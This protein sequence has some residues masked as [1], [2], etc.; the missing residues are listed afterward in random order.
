M[1]QPYRRNHYGSYRQMPMQNNLME[2]MQMIMM[3]KMMNSMGP[4]MSNMG[5]GMSSMG[6]GMGGMGPGMSGMG[7]GMSG[8][9]PG[10]SG[11]GPG[12]GGM[13][14]GMGG[15]GP[16]MGSMVQKMGGMGY[17]SMT[18]MMN[19]KGQGGYSSNRSQMRLQCRPATRSNP[20]ITPTT[21]LTITPTT[22]PTTPTTPP[23]TV[24]STQTP[25]QA[26]AQFPEADKK[27]ADDD[28]KFKVKRIIKEELS[29]VLKDMMT[30]MN[31]SDRMIGQ[32]FAQG[33]LSAI[34]NFVVEN[35]T[36]PSAA[37]P[38]ADM[39][40]PCSSNPCGANARCLS[41]RSGGFT[42]EC[43][44][45]YIRTGQTCTHACNNSPYPAL[46]LNDR[47][48]TFHTSD[49]STAMT[50]V[51]A[52]AM[53]EARGGSM[54]TVKN[55]IEWVN[56]THWLIRIRLHNFSHAHFE[57]PWLGTTRQPNNSN[58]WK[59]EGMAV[60]EGYTFWSV[61]EP[62]PPSSGKHCANIN[63]NNGKAY[64]QM[65]GRRITSCICQ[66]NTPL[67]IMK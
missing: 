47:C 21:P 12:M 58:L 31:E 10:M 41:H 32:V 49:S 8:M 4:G 5:P 6:P 27:M 13:G 9:G 42:C 14:P 26:R 17:S 23:T 65:C 38:I 61:G 35:V 66:Y 24:T 54:L 3:M 2:M 36:T 15:M 30:A 55:V 11:M 62:M 46:A 22:S 16:G 63:A 51:A 28:F 43:S 64:S 52:K 50:Y 56:V 29:K 44:P 20:L 53:C 40:D 33:V 19:S 59:Y 60:G 39:V 25:I 37:E 67:N 57:G 18:G 1:R 7:P 45:G 34:S 48:L